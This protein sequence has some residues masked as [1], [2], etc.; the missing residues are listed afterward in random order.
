[1]ASQPRSER[2]S[3]NV[4]QVFSVPVQHIKR[5][6]ICELIKPH[7]QFMGFRT[8]MVKIMHT[9]APSDGGGFAIFTP[10]PAIGLDFILSF[11]YWCHGYLL[12]SLKISLYN[13]IQGK[14]NGK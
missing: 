4:M 13:I 1:M 12:F 2:N 11:E 6:A 10:D 5:I 9:A 7:Q 8:Q 3:A 14:T